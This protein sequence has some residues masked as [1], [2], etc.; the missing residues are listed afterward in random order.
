MDYKNDKE[1]FEILQHDIRDRLS[2]LIEHT[3]LEDITI[4]LAKFANQSFERTVNF[5]E[6]LGKLKEDFYDNGFL[7]EKITVYHNELPEIPKLFKRIGGWTIANLSYMWKSGKKDCFKCWNMY[8]SDGENIPVK[9]LV[10]KQKWCVLYPELS[11]AKD[12]KFMETCPS[13]KDY[14]FN[15]KLDNKR[16]IEIVENQLSLI[17]NFYDSR[18]KKK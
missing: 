16:K 6:E 14:T 10:S 11:E 18:F 3:I 15:V 9:D 4:E 8:K 13:F 17:Y 12:W 1:I 5:E 7:T 2:M